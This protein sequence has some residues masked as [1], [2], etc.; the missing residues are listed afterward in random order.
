MKHAMARLVWAA[1]MVAALHTFSLCG[2][3]PMPP[4]ARLA[5]IG[6]SITEQR[7]YTR[8]M[9]GYLLACASRLDVR[10]F[11]YGWSG[12]TAGGFAG[13]LENDLAGFNPTVATTCYGMNDGQYRPF[14]EAIGR[15]YEANMRKV[16]AGLEKI[17]VQRIV[18]GSPG[19]VDTR[20]FA[21]QNFAPLSGAEGYNANLAELGNINRRLASEL[22]LVFADVHQPMIDAMAKAKA[23][24]GQD[25]D[26]CGRDG[27]HPGPNG[28]LIMAYAFLRALGCDGQIADLALDMKGRAIGSTGHRVVSASAGQATFE[29][30]RYP[31]CHDG[32]AKS[33]G[34]TRSIAP[35]VPFDAELN[36]FMLKVSGLEAA[37]ARV[38]W[39][40]E[41]R[42]FSRA[43]LERGVNL[44]A[45]FGSTPFDG[46][47][48]RVIEAVS[49]KQRF[50][51]AM[52]K[53][54][55]TQ[56]R[57]FAQETESSPELAE[58][59]RAVRQR[60]LV[61]QAELDA[62][63]RRAIVPVEHTVRVAPIP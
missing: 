49:A 26:V 12:E 60:L 15:P 13:R 51:T 58:A 39:G 16:A 23:A 22:G 61:R 40:D 62:A 10:V 35:F 46:A 42:E 21:R 6:D 30:V 11:Q 34:G 28:H 14:S 53:S 1:G 9:E 57:Q 24:L 19:A 7:I 50:E 25:Y 4:G 2:A 56:F 33:S 52:I 59:F 48:R 63:V 55:V 54:M 43:Q 36:R 8:Y 29:S 18:L 45:E 32:D 27:F 5:I 3:E 44:A 41:S 47:F 37:R 20:Y 31:F 38:T 17:G